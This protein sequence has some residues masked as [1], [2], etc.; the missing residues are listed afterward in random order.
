MKKE[1]SLIIRK[2]RST[3]LGELGTTASH[4]HGA[5]VLLIGLSGRIRLHFQGGPS[6][7]CYSALIDAGV[8][9][10]LD[11]QGERIATIYSEVSSP[12]TLLLRSLYLQSQPYAFDVIKPSIFLHRSEQKILNFDLI[13]MLGLNRLDSLPSL[14]SRVVRCI[15]LLNTPAYFSAGQIAIAEQ[16]QLSASRLNHLFKQG[17][18]VSYRRYRLWSQL[19]FFMRNVKCTNNLTESAL[20][21]GF[22]DA[23]HLSNSYRKLFGISPAGLLKGLDHF[24]VDLN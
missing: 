14:D 24:E 5:L 4:Q 15:E 9:H 7:D 22:F 13:S 11:P 19:A 2:Y 8:A 3:Y 21:S 17:T 18:G 23:S 1:T 16:V 10:S 20:N 12:E 6:I